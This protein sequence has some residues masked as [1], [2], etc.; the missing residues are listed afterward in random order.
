MLPDITGQIGIEE[1]KQ[2]VPTQ[3]R[4]TLDQSFV[5]LVNSFVEDEAREAYLRDLVTYVSVLN[6]GKFKLK[7]YFNA[8]KFVGFRALGKTQVEAY[9]LTFPDRYKGHMARGT[10]M[11]YI[12]QYASQYAKSMLVTKLTQQQ[13]IPTHLAYQHVFA[14]AIQ[15]QV[16]LMRDPKVS[17]KVRSDAAA[18]LM[19][20][21]APP[22]DAKV[23][24]E[25]GAKTSNALDDIYNQLSDIAKAQQ[26]Q[27]VNGSASAKDVAE[28]TINV[29]IDGEAR[30]V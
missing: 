22:V 16:S 4:K 7:D 26:Q 6:E 30:H 23:Q 25:I 2:L 1:L 11:E 13:L 17:P 5:D 10:P 12:A 15:T 18:H 9:V 24:L 21:L 28:A 29:V 27:I 3:F 20:T 8:I 19:K 14:E